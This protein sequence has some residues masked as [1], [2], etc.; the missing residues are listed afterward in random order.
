[1]RPYQAEQR[2]IVEDY[3]LVTIVVVIVSVCWTIGNEV[4]LKIGNMGLELVEGTAAALINT[5][6]LFWRIAPVILIIGVLVWAVARAF[7]KEPYAQY[8]GWG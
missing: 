1:M 7:K 8:T 3:V 2:G 5:L 4:V 6:I